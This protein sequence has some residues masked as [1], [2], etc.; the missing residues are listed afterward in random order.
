MVIKF[1]LLFANKLISK[2][3]CIYPLRVVE[4]NCFWR[5]LW[6]MLFAHPYWSREQPVRRLR[7]SYRN[8]RNTPPDCVPI[9]KRHGKDKLVHD[10]PYIKSRGRL[11]CRGR[12]KFLSYSNIIP[13]VLS[14]IWHPPKLISSNWISKW[15]TISRNSVALFYR[16]M[17]TLLQ[18]P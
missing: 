3:A 7:F 13:P 10:V 5:L 11:C 12:H 9:I 15:K 1:G 4:I 16:Q 8:A 17:I 6:E 18:F 2:T 14:T